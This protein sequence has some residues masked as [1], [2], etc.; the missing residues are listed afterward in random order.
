MPEQAHN[1]EKTCQT[2]RFK[3]KNAQKSEICVI[4]QSKTAANA[5]REACRVGPAGY[6]TISPGDTKT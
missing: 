3:V 4:R 2:I 5:K 1:S 6:T